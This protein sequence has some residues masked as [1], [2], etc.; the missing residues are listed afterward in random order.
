MELDGVFEGQ[1]T[2]ARKTRDDGGSSSR[3]PAKHSI[4]NIRAA[5]DIT[6]RNISY[7]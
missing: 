2:G 3:L 5:L 6:P 1:P 4:Q 7:I